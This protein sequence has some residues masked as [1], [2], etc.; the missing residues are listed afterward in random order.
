LGELRGTARKRQQL[1]KGPFDSVV[2]VMRWSL[3]V[4]A[5]SG[6]LTTDEVLP[7]RVKE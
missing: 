3:R 1:P 7:F 4:D 6:L 2:G 5:C